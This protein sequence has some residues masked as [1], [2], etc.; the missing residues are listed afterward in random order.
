MPLGSPLCCGIQG[1]FP[2]SCLPNCQ[3][4]QGN[5]ALQLGQLPWA[6]EAFAALSCVCFFILMYRAEGCPSYLHREEGMEG[7]KMWL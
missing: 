7:L 3:P 2:A 6:Q 4:W 1:I 5:C